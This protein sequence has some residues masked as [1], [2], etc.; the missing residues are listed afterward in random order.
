M[1]SG[2]E[3]KP[4]PCDRLSA[5]PGECWV[6]L[7]DLRPGAIFETLS[8]VRAVKSEYHLPNGNPRCILLES[9]EL[10]HFAN[11][12]DILCRELF[13]PTA[14]ATP[15]PNP[16]SGPSAFRPSSDGDEAAPCAPE[17]GGATRSSC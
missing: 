5:A 7:C 11:G 3:K 17:P 1:T 15:E 12:K 9:G 13:L 4:N 16:S 8:G 6:P 14:P 2:T 10:A